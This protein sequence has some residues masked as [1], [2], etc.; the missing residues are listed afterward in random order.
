MGEK[1]NHMEI[2]KYFELKNIIRN[3]QPWLVWLNGL[4][5]GL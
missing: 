2:R 3:F 4:S 5:A 1:R